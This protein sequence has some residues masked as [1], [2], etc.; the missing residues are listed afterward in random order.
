MDKNQPTDEFQTNLESC[1][2]GL[3]DR[4]CKKLPGVTI[5]AKNGSVKS[6]R[7][8]FANSVAFFSTLLAA[9]QVQLQSKVS[10]ICISK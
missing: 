8:L 9:P 7:L 1:E 2:P 6:V 3:Q 4:L 5:E 10:L